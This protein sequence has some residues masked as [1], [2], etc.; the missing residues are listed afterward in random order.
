[1]KK[2]SWKAASNLMDRQYQEASRYEPPSVHTLSTKQKEAEVDLRLKHQ[3]ID[4]MADCQDDDDDGF[5]LDLALDFCKVPNRSCSCV[6]V[7]CHCEL[8]DCFFRFLPFS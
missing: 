1:M 6:N 8:L 2:K 7:Y 5:P 3:Q 4:L